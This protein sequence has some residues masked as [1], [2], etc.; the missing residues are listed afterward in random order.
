MKIYG[1]KAQIRNFR[2]E[3]IYLFGKKS[4]IAEIISYLKKS[5]QIVMQIQRNT[6]VMITF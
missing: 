4:K 3:L 5:P 1:K 2:K 6:G